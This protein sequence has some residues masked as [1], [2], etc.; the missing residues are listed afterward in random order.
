MKILTSHLVLTTANV[1]MV[2][3]KEDEEE[4]DEEEESRHLS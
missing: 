2:D 4:E 3:G 1:L